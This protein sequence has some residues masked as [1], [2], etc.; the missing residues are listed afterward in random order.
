MPRRAPPTLRSVTLMGFKE[1]HT[2]DFAGVS[3]EIGTPLKRS[4]MFS[5]KIL[6]WTRVTNIFPMITDNAWQWSLLNCENVFKLCVYR[7]TLCDSIKN[8]KM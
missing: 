4:S 7:S 6:N 3:I 5:K 1:L 8:D 2:S